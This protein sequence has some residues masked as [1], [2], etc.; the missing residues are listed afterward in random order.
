MGS[1]G[2]A[3]TPS[4]PAV[5]SVGPQFATD[6]N[7]ILA[8]VVAR[9]SA[10]VPLGSLDVS[11]DLNLSGSRILNAGYVSFT[12]IAATPGA[13]PANR[14]TTFAGDLYYVSP[15]GV[16]QLTTGAALNAAAVGGITGAYGGANPA[17][18]RYDNVNAR[19]DA[20]A[21]FGTNT[22]SD[23]RALGFQVAASATSAIFA[24][25]MFGGVAN[26]TYTLPTTAAT[27]NDRPL[28]MDSTGQIT[29][30]HGTKTYLYGVQG[31]V[32][33][34]G[35]LVSG[36]LDGGVTNS[37]TTAIATDISVQGLLTEFKI[38]S[39]IFSFSKTTAA[40]TTF[41][42]RKSPMGGPSVV[43]ATLNS[44]TI[45][46][47]QSVTV[48]LGAP[49]TVTAGVNYYVSYANTGG[50]ANSDTFYGFQILGNLP[51]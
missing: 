4:I 19:Y 14:L 9:L 42:L 51:A 43:L 31:V 33:R 8:E 26:K 48:A 37:T 24:R 18:F 50:T 39:V 16:I 28:Y 35:A 44:T 32:F 40:A 3:I 6:I 17:Q 46:N 5:G 36:T 11:T 21:N 30:G 45:G 10:K 25:L 12:N 34:G 7:A 41:T 1:I 23:V 29:V 22:L 15:S 13:S 49:E 20:Y 47:N 27:G 2:Q 38:N